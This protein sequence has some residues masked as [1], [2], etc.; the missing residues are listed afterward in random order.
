MKKIL[1]VDDQ[2]TIRRLVQISL[3]STERQILQAES[4][5]QAIDL[6]RTERPDLIIMDIM[7]PGGMDG[8]E[9]VAALR[10]QPETRECPVLIL[11]AK[12]QKSERIRAVEM[13]VGDYLAKP[14]KLESLVHKVDNLLH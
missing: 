1:V 6:A 4:G 12:D 2:A 5:E 9:A 7:M 8:F 11:T 10:E 13:G 3:K 14:F